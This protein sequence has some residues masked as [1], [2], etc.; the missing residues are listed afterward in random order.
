M[1]FP[2]LILLLG[3]NSIAQGRLL[4]QADR[5]CHEDRFYN[6]GSHIIDHYFGDRHYIT[7]I[8]TKFDGEELAEA[9]EC[10]VHHRPFYIVTQQR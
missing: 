10:E 7:V 1:S 6:L 8:K 4:S 5:P 2:L 3:V 9:F